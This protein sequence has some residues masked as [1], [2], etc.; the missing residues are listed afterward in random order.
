MIATIINACSG[1]NYLFVARN[2]V[3]IPCK[4]NSLG[5]WISFQAAHRRVVDSGIWSV[6]FG[7]ASQVTMEGSL[8]YKGM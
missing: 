8:V 6:T 7:V 1:I 4:G 3:I 2:S 5:K